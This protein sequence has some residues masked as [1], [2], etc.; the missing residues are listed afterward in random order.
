VTDTL[1]RLS[2]RRVVVASVA[3]F[4]DTLQRTESS[5]L[6]G[7]PLETDPEYLEV[8]VDL[9]IDDTAV[10]VF[11]NAGQDEELITEQLANAIAD[12]GQELLGSTPFPPCPGHAHPLVVTSSRNKVFWCCPANRNTASAILFER[13]AA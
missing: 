12:R 5:E 11:V 9:C 1:S 2:G 3:L 6:L 10:R 7:L 13:R 8:A 4:D